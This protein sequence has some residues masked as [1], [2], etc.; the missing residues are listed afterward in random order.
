MAHANIVD[1]I[2]S[3]VTVFTKDGNAAENRQLHTIGTQCGAQ[4]T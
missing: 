2:G 3:K 4:N 1:H